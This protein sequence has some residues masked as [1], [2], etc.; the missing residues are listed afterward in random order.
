MAL[1]GQALLALWND[2]A[3]AREAEY[4]Q[5]HSLEHVPER[6]AATG[7][8]GARRYVNRE[9]ASHRYFTLYDVESLAVFE[10]PEY[11]DLLRNPTPWSDSMRPDFANFLRAPCR[12]RASTGT[13][14]GAAL[15]CVC[16]QECAVDAGR[17]RAALAHA[18]ALPRVTSAH[19]G[20][21]E[22][23]LPSVP[24]KQSPTATVEPRAF[25]TVVLIEA[26]DRAAAAAALAALRAAFD[27]QALPADFGADVYDLALAFPGT[28]PAERLRHRRPGWTKLSPMV[29]DAC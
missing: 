26:L 8:H 7:I 15:A 11:V 25:D 22:G 23:G 18:L 3:P 29:P 19:W 10:S 14:I 9:R 20:T 16:V 4:D 1:R 21:G 6:V 13:G 5:W 2:I 17:I 27:L 28:D 12:V 24:W